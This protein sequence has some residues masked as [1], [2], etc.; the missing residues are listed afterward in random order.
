MFTTEKGG[1]IPVKVAEHHNSVKEE[2]L[3]KSL[4]K[5]KVKLNEINLISFSHGPGLTPSLVV[6]MDFAKKLSK[7]LRI[8]VVGVNHCI[9]HLEIG[10]ML[11]P[12]CKD[13][14]LLYT[15]GANTQVIA[16]EGGKYRIFGE[17]LDNGIGN[18]L[19]SF[20]RHIGIGFPAGP[21]IEKLALKGKKYIEIPYCVKGMD[22][23]FG[24]ILT[25][26]KQKVNSGRY[27]LEDLCYSLQETVFAMLIEVGERA[28]AHCEKN[29]LL[30]GGGVACNKRLQ[31]MADI[32]CKE[33]SAICYIP[34][35][36]FLVD[37][38]AMIAWLGLLVYKAADIR[39]ENIS[40]F[41]N[42]RT[43]DVAVTW[44]H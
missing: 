33:R 31:E 36:Q 29:E 39:S 18:V 34:E 21:Q 19:D 28:M 24:G 10:R 35:N 11:F 6:G 41:P 7:D 12:E 17:T 26:L 32:M 25:N 43:D 2:V 37:N 44:K 22:V 16:Y 38:P 9:A 23:N 1:M 15:S 5:A 40:I 30:L 3:Q 20:G 27:Q 14:V 13:P 8:P 4:E 42:E